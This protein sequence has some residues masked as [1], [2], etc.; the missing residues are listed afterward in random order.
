MNGSGRPAPGRADADIPGGSVL[1][2]VPDRSRHGRDRGD[3]LAPKSV[4]RVD[5][6]VL[7]VVALYLLA[8]RAPPP[9]PLLLGI[10]TALFAVVVIGLRWHRFPVRGSGPR[11]ALGAAAMVAYITI[12]A[13]Q[14]GAAGSVLVNLYLLPI[15]LVAMTLGRSGAIVVFLSVALAYASLVLGEPQLPPAAE[16]LAGLFGTLCPFALVAYLTHALSR[17]IVTARRRIEAMAE[18]DALTGTF[19]LRTFGL[20][21][22][23]EHHLRQRAGRGSYGILIVDMDQLK[24]LND[25]HGQAAGNLAI[26]TVAA[27]IQRAVRATDIV[28]RSGGDEFVIFL[29]ESIPE[30]ADGV[31]QRIRN[32]VFRSLFPVGERLQRSSVAVGAASYPQDGA[33][34]DDI[35]AAAT[36]RMLSDKNLRRQKGTAAADGTA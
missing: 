7:L 30:V 25:E 11:I 21:L 24:K 14:T 22:K 12:V 23:R 16:L 20:L 5:W 18:R 6:L 36:T 32:N 29:P 3:G 10:A 28:A 26:T 4:A 8:R 19:N 9:Q 27:A 13:M 34:P 1:T 15:V 35:V 2:P 31:A 33:N 17:S